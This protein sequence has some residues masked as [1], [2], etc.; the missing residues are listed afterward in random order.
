MRLRNLGRWRSRCWR[1]CWLLGCV[2][3]CSY[4]GFDLLDLDGSDLP[5]R[6][7]LGGEISVTAQAEAEQVFRFDLPPSDEWS[8]PGAQATSFPDTRLRIAH[9]SHTVTRP[10]SILLPR[11]HLSLAAPISSATPA[12]PA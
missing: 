8:H 12:D 7:G 9:Q 10:R 4:I 3:L 1:W 6:L 2:L 5:N 11:K